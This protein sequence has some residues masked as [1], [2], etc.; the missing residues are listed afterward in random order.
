MPF[1]ALKDQFDISIASTKDIMKTEDS[2]IGG[3]AILHLMRSIWWSFLVRAE[4]SVSKKK[5]PKAALR[6]MVSKL[7]AKEAALCLFAASDAHLTL[8]LN[9]QIERAQYLK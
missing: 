1:L 2:E 3:P 9:V 4:R 7:P 6:D 5:A 8:P